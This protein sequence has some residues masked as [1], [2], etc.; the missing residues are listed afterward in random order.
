MSLTQLDNLDPEFNGVDGLD[1]TG[2]APEDF[3]GSLARDTD[4]S[5]GDFVAEQFSNLVTLNII[6]SLPVPTPTTVDLL[7]PAPFAPLFA[8]G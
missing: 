4:H 5:A 1:P 6:P 8:A 7:E 3:S 2:I